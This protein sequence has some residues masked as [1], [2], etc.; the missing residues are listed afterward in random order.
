MSLVRHHC[1]CKRRGEEALVFALP[2][3]VAE[4]TMA[5]HGLSDSM[6]EYQSPTL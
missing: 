4:T 6:R 1:V 5:R 2:P 3:P